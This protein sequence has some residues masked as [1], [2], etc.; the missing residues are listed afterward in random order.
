MSTRVFRWP[1]WRLWAVLVLLVGALTTLST[2]AVGAPKPKP[3]KTD[4]K[5]DGRPKIVAERVVAI[6][7][8]AIILESELEARMLPLLS[9]LASVTD[10]GE[11][12]RRLGKIRGATLDDMINEELIVQAGEQAKIE[13][14]PSEIQ[15]ALDEIKR[16]NQIDDAG[17]LQ[18]LAAEGFTLQ[19]Y[20]TDL[21]R[22][23]LRLRTIN[24]IVAPKVNISDDDALAR[25]NELQRRSQ[26]VGKVRLAHI[27][28]ATPDH[29]TEQDI[30]AAK[31]RAANALARI[32]AGE[33]WNA[34]CLDVSDDQSTKQSGGELSWFERGQLTDPEWDKVVFSMEKGDVRGPLGGQDGFHLF[35]A[36]EIQSSGLKPFADMKEQIKGELRH[37]EMEK[38]TQIWIDEL[39]KKAY[40]D[41]KSQ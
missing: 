20:K 1:G 31:Q 32:R 18:L 39:R 35:K 27:L 14:E 7:N 29:P 25:Y 19:N 4:D 24:T 37:R 10:P 6:V 17:L 9:E 8:D 23:I 28:F 38:A 12:D 41:L 5:D 26:A 36:L 11:R 22:Q 16:Q 30:A 13:V 33:D 34:V 2:V 21:R 3:T 40:I 15:A